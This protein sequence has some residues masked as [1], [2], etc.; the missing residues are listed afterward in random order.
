MFDER[1]MYTQSSMFSS[2]LCICE[3]HIQLDGA[4]EVLHI[5]QILYSD[6]DLSL[7]GFIRNDL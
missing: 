5:L 7:L 6:D 4:Q 1:S 2:L 3:V